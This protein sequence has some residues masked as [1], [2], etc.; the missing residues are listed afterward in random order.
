MGIMGLFEILLV[1]FFPAIIF[2]GILLLAGIR[3]INQWETGVRFRLGRY[4]DTLEPGLRFIIPI[5]D[6]IKR[7]DMRLLTIDIPRQQVITKDNVPVT[8]NGVVYFKVVDAATAIIKVQDYIYAVSQYAQTALRDVAGGMTLDQVLGERENI[9]K[10]I[11]KIVEEAS[12]NW[13]IEITDIK[14]QDIDMP[15]DL[16]RLMSRQASSEREKRATIIKAEGDKMAAENLA[17]AAET[18]M[19]SPGAMQL[20]TLQTIDGLGPTASNTV[21]LAVPVDMFELI[22]NISGAI[23]KK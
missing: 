15:E 4:K 14:L 8:I 1:L 23:K 19:K 17:K 11:E 13:G 16:K 10:D 3:I 21:V 7:V 6:G 9:G 2:F 22:R 5:L 20:R 12:K 18:M